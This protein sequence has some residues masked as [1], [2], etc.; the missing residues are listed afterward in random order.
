MANAKLTIYN[1]AAVTNATVV[2]FGTD[3]LKK[4]KGIM[5]KIA[6]ISTI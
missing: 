2:I 6:A 5:M 4:L 1:T 3:F